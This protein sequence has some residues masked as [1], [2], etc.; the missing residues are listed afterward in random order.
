MFKN[1]TCWKTEIVTRSCGL[2]LFCTESVF[3]LR[4]VFRV[5]S[6][7]MTVHETTTTFMTLPSPIARD[8]LILKVPPVAVF[9]LER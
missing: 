7:L 8:H 9:S 4:T 1:R 5:Y 6:A 2:D 3:G